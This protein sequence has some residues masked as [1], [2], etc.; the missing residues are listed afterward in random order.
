MPLNTLEISSSLQETQEIDPGEPP[1][2]PV[3]E[4]KH[5]V[6]IGTRPWVNMV[7]RCSKDVVPVGWRRRPDRLLFDTPHAAA[8]RDALR[9]GD[10]DVR[11]RRQSVA[12]EEHQ[13]VGRVSRRR[14]QGA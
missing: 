6:K 4:P 10:R 11:M 13:R 14:G 9:R 2:V 1:I 7:R 3:P 5:C 12:S 8:R